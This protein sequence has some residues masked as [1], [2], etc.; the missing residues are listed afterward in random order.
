[1]TTGLVERGGHQIRAAS[2]QCHP[3]WRKE[4]CRWHE[5]RPQRIARMGQTESGRGCPSR[6][7]SLDT[8]REHQGA[9][10]MPWEPLMLR[11]RTYWERTWR[12][13]E[14]PPGRREDT[15]W[16]CPLLLGKR[17]ATIELTQL[18]LH[19]ARFW[20]AVTEGVKYLQRVAV[21][22]VTSWRIQGY[23]CW[24]CIL[25]ALCLFTFFSNN[26]FLW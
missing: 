20:R 11:S 19:G 24:A 8:E 6:R 3:A 5:V 22:G 2:E 17:V 21:D 1:M 7:D 13:L 25:Y 18:V 14:G 26:L 10:P 23:K 9:E 15:A 4:S 12:R 16:V